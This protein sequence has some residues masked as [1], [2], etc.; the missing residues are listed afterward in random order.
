[1]AAGTAVRVLARQ[2]REGDHVRME[3]GVGTVRVEYAGGIIPSRVL[4]RRAERLTKFFGLVNR[5]KTWDELD[6][7]VA[8]VS[9]DS[10]VEVITP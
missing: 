3:D 6:T 5:W 9:V 1:M 2:L 4:V 10:E 8:E 7:P